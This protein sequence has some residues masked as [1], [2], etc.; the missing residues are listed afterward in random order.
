MGRD[1]AG[2]RRVVLWSRIGR[3]G[4]GLLAVTVAP[5]SW[6]LVAGCAAQ[7][8]ATGS[9]VVH[10]TTTAPAAG[11]FPGWWVT[12]ASGWMVGATSLGTYLQRTDDGGSTWMPQLRLEFPRLFARDISVIDSSHAFVVTLTNGGDQAVPHLLATDDGRTWS[13]RGLPPISQVGGIA[14][15]TRQS[16]WLLG[17]SSGQTALLYWTGDGGRSWREAAGAG[18]LPLGQNVHL[19]GLRVTGGRLWAGGWHA[20]EGVVGRPMLVAL[21]APAG[22]V[23]GAA[24]A[25]E[26]ALP[27][28]GAVGSRTGLYV[29]PPQTS[30]DGH[31]VAAVTSVG[32]GTSH[33]RVGTLDAAGGG[34]TELVA[35]PT[36]SAAWCEWSSRD[37]LIGT[38]ART[39][40]WTGGAPDS[41][42]AGGDLPVPGRP[43]G[44]QC[45]GAGSAV[46]A[47]A[48]GRGHTAV[49]RTD[50]GGR[51]WKRLP[52]GG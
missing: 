36:T 34:W 3:T 41:V 7:P 32:D 17:A 33:V 48:L 4:V 44:L 18:S 40:R 8:A 43:V 22:G 11:F 45:L 50:D 47:E 42:A 29:D 12:S 2:R 51:T 6:G 20:V 24:R 30:P 49:A 16:G 28:G 14:F 26:I 13:E 31:L 39:V 25:I 37:L 5:L 23:V 1:Q 10:Q 35:Q 9:Q 15:T 19:E 46:V 52:I 27:G 38:E 21:E